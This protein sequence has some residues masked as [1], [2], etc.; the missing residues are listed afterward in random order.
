M[1]RS[2][3][4]K[5]SK[6]D[7]ASLRRNYTKGGIDDADL[8]ENPV[9]L[10]QKWIDQAID[11]NVNE[12]N[13]MS[14]ATVTPDGLP[15]VRIVLLK[16]FNDQS[17]QFYTNYKS[18]KALEI[19]HAP[20]AAVAFWWP[21]MERQVRVRGNVKKVSRDET[22]QYFKSRPRES[23]IGA[24][25]S[26]QSSEIESRNVLVE[27]AKSVARRFK[28]KDVPV[29]EFW[30]GYNIF[31]TQIEFWQGRPGRL[32]DRILYTFDQDSWTFKRL[33]P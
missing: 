10:L 24:W 3:L 32:H 20:H 7:V 28:G 14:L 30:G 18:S 16:G 5:K 22:E 29:P 8:P 13:A 9:D 12:P 17:I 26:E 19:E 6:N 11:A 23:Q 27:K 2:T 31:Y 33:Q 1:S 15:N 4:D 21:E 25:V